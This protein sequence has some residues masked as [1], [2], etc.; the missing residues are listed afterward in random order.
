MRASRS[1]H[2]PLMAK[3]GRLWEHQVEQSCCMST[4]ER[5]VSLQGPGASWTNRIVH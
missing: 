4:A 5:P 1:L 2:L 3:A